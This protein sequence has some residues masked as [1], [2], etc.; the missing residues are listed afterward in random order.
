MRLW[1][2]VA[3]SDFFSIIVAASLAPNEEQTRYRDFK[4]LER[5]HRYGSYGG[6]VEG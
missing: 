3:G 2:L 6:G 5:A 1:G 4:K